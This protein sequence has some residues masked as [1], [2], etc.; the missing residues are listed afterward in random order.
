VM[1]LADAGRCS[2]ERGTAILPAARSRSA[3]VPQRWAP[4]PDLPIRELAGL[5]AEAVAYEGEILWD[6]R[7]HAHATPKNNSTSQSWAPSLEGRI[8]HLAEGRVRR[9]GLCPSGCHDGHPFR[10]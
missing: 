7:K 5:V 6:I 3:A 1:M 9:P 4:G 10:R 2:P 8:R